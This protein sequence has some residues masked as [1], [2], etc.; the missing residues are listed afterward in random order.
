MERNDSVDISIVRKHTLHQSSRAVVAFFQ[1]CL[2]HRCRFAGEVTPSLSNGNRGAGRVVSTLIPT[3][4]WRECI[5]SE[6]V[7]T[8]FQNLSSADA[9]DISELNGY[10]VQLT[11]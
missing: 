11:H 4:T 6:A 7:R 2:H 3:R 8:L 10:D 5:A 9:N 1:S